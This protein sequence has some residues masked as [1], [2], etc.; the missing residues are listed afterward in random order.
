MAAPD[1]N[2]DVVP[3]PVPSSGGWWASVGALLGF[4]LDVLPI[5]S[6]VLPEGW[7]KPLP[8]VGAV[9]GMALNRFFRPAYK[10]VNPP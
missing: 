9:I 2:P 8:V 10:P 4:I 6:P 7:S 1:T 3:Q 5:L